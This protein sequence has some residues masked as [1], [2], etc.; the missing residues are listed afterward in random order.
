MVSPG[1]VKQSQEYQTTPCGGTVAGSYLG[2]PM[3][4]CEV[5]GGVIGEG[6]GQEPNRSSERAVVQEEATT[7]EW[8]LLPS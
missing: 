6:G 1:A 5:R 4:D 3:E 7:G 8:F 2:H